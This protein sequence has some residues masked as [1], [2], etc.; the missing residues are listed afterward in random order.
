MFGFVVNYTPKLFWLNLIFLLSIVLMPFSTS[1]Y[2]SYSTPEHIYLVLPFAIYA[3]NISFTGIMN[4]VLLNYIF[5]PENGVA[6]HIPS[7]DQILFS[8]RRALAIP[9]IF[10]ISVLL[11]IFLPGIGRMFLFVIPFAM[12]FLRTKGNLNKSVEEKDTSKSD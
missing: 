9:A 7:K 11:T 1:V 2:S 10:S 12:K 6:E 4:Y 8:K 5:K 3:A